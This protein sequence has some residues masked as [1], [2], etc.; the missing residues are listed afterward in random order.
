[1]QVLLTSIER[2]S[3]LLYTCCQEIQEPW[4]SVPRLG[5][6]LCHSCEIPSTIIGSSIGICQG[7]NVVIDTSV[8]QAYTAQPG[9]QEWVTIIECISATGTKIPPYVI[10]KDK[11]VI[12]S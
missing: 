5:A 3:T 8:K 4:L 10:F 12:S 9:R 11:N 6:K 7:T 1:M 2:E